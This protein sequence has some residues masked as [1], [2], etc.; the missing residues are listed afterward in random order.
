MTTRAA[1]AAAADVLAVPAGVVLATDGPPICAAEIAQRSGAAL[2]AGVRPT[3]MQLEFARIARFIKFFTGKDL[4]TMLRDG[5]DLGYRGGGGPRFVPNHASARAH[6]AGVDAHVA[7]YVGAGVLSGPH[8]SRPFARSEVVVSP[9]GAVPKPPDGVRVI[10]DLTASGV[11]AG[12]A[13]QPFSFQSFDE[14]T[15]GIDSGTWM[16]KLDIDSAYLRVAVRPEDFHLLGV[17]WRGHYFYFTRLP[18]GARSAPFLFCLLADAVRDAFVAKWRGVFQFTLNSYSDDSF[19]KSQSEEDLK[20]VAALW[21]RTLDACGLDPSTKPDKAVGPCK[22]LVIRGVHIDSATGVLSLPADKLARWRPTLATWLQGKISRK[23]LSRLVGKLGWLAFIQ[24]L[25]RPF[26]RPFTDLLYA[27]HRAFDSDDVLLSPVESLLPAET[28]FFRELL[29]TPA[30]WRRMY[31]DG[32]GDVVVVQADASWRS[33]CGGAASSDRHTQVFDCTAAVAAGNIKDINELG[34]CCSLL[35]ALHWAARVPAGS[36]LCVMSDNG[37]TVGWLRRLSVPGR[38]HLNGLVQRLA[39]AASAAALS[40]ACEH[41]P[42][43]RNRVADALSRHKP[44]D[45]RFWEDLAVVPAS[46]P[47]LG[48]GCA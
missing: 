8:V 44:I 13:Q 21:A 35:A 28:A 10:L 23:D 25:C 2:Q 24:P 41:V 34:C 11:N 14:F 4:S 30:F 12:I 16:S 43:S 18:F 37:A 6:A 19:A 40:V 27:D 20:A 39:L 22:A 7:A 26:V 5:A 29:E 47:L 42:G 9:L 32:A 17:W 45:E 1:D 31:A 46:F 38:P 15:A 33:G 48:L 36:R 3:R